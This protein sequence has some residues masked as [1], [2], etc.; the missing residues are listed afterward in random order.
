MTETAVASTVAQPE[1]SQQEITRLKKVIEVLMDRAERSTSIQSSGFGLLQSTVVLEKK[2]HER[3]RDLEE[4]LRKIESINEALAREKAEQQELIY[5]LEDAHHKLLQSEKLAAIGQLAAGVAHEINNPI[6]FVMA[7]L[8]TLQKYADDLLAILGAY[9]DAAHQ[10][11]MAPEFAS[12]IESLCREADIDYL[13]SDIPSLITESIDGADRVRRIVLDLRSFTRTGSTVPEMADLHAALDSTL[14]IVRNEVK[15]K[16]EVVKEYG[17]LPPLRCV[18]AQINQVFLNL[19]V[20]A[21]QAIKEKGIITVRSGRDGDT[22]WISISDTGGGISPDNLPRVFDPFFTTRRAGEGTGLGLSVS[23]DIVHRHG[24]R[25]DVESEPGT[26][27][28]FTLRLPMTSE[29]EIE[30]DVA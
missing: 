19:I 1:T 15:Y 2:I 23:R 8:G 9:G 7:N 28:T 27:T 26:G 16:A 25:L 4:A 30:G 6:A 18:V 10:L 17:D 20:N 3:T 21:A 13:I 22:G 24:G 14:N 29:P 5:K 11:T 12:H